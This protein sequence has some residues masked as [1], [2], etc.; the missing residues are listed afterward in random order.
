MSI[1]QEL[2]PEKRDTAATSDLLTARVIDQY[3]RI[4]DPRLRRIVTD[5][6]RHLH[7]YVKE[8]R[9][10]DAEYESAWT[11]LNDM[12]KW[13]SGE[14]NEFLT[15][16]DV[17][18]ISQLIEIL[19]HERAKSSVGYSVVGPVYRANAPL[20]RSGESI[21]SED[22]AGQRV[23]ITGKVQD[24]TTNAPIPGA[25]LDVWQAATN[26]LYENQDENQP[27][28]N[29]RGRYETDESGTFELVALFPTHYPIPIDGPIGKLLRV[30][31]R[32]P[33]RPAHIHFIVSAPGFETLVT[34]VFRDDDPELDSDVTFTADRS[35]VGRFERDG[36]EYRLRYDFQLRSGVRTEPKAP[37]L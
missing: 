2:A 8:V 34:Q 22:T 33:Y 11:F 28:Y 30:A 26:G 4:E 36:G 20:R 14:R 12:A 25:L 18:G 7:A 31:K 1:Q 10:T 21:A 19:N 32:H 6:L 23:R 27:D 35:M 15:L 3:S 9:P 24:L 16:A 17:V 37:I 5:L 13:T 29:L